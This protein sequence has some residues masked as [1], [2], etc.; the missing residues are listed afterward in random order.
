MWERRSAFHVILMQHFGLSPEHRLC[1]FGCGPLRAGRYLI[2]YLDEGNYAGFDFNQDFLKI[3]RDL[4]AQAPHLSCKSPT[5]EGTDTDAFIEHQHDYILMFSALNH[6][7]FRGQRE[8][9]LK[10]FDASQ[11]GATLI[12]THAQKLCAEWDSYDL[13]FQKKEYQKGDWPADIYPSLHR[14]EEGVASNMF[15]IVKL[16]H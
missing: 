6:L 12:I 16:T 2:D 1:D 5:V 14:W 13:N 8:A 11:K 15:P 10:K 3:G 4:I 9:L 7:R